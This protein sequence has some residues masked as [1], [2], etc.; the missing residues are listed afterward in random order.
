MSETRRFG[1]VHL[2]PG[3]LPHHAGTFL[4][5]A[6]LSIALTTFI[7]VIQPYVLRVNLGLPQEIQG[8]V[9]GDMVFYS[10]IV[11]LL[12]S[13]VVGALSDRFGR[14]N[15]FVIGL[16]ILALGYGMYA[17]VASVSG[18]ALVRIFLAF[19]IAI[20]NVMVAAIQADYPQEQSRGKLVGFTGV[21]I[22][23]GALMI[24][25]FFTQLPYI[26]ANVMASD[27]LAG[28]YTMFTMA[29][30][31][32]ILLI[33]CHLGLKRGRSTD[34]ADRTPF[35]TSLGQGFTAAKNNQKILLSYAAAFVARADLVVV[36][37]FYSLW[38]TQAGENA[39]MSAEKA[40][41]TAGL[42]FGLVMGV[43]LLWA[44]ILGIINDRLNR[45]T[46]M[47]LALGLA[48]LGYGS[49]GFI[50]DPLGGW[51][52][53]AA[54]L[55]GI[56]QI[57]AVSA[58]QTLIGQEAPAP[59]RGSVIGMFSLCGAAGILFITSIGGR[60]YDA[61]DPTAPFVLIGAINGLL[62]FIALRVKRRERLAIA[63]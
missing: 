44:P 62:F 30:L 56:G 11:L 39:G 52:Y 48:A 1:P 32:V 36:G 50:G 21:A 22:G 28:R 8:Q 45:T 43:A 51:M 24:G 20:V 53:P 55:L 12:L 9:S 37:T 2:A 59:I 41:S 5:A 58:S 3:V 40:S 27:L 49:M 61:I 47:A 26:Y 25:I 17:Y 23:V 57:S 18:L 33:V 14:R 63:T 42:F 15:M 46:T 54:A 38:L 16:A 35:F 19:G 29:A 13:G 6:F 10:E 31:S 4:F 34:H 7:S 60:L